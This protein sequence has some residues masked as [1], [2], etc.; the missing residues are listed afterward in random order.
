MDRLFAPV[1]LLLYSMQTSAALAPIA[2]ISDLPT[3]IQ[4]CFQSG[5]C[6][7][8][9]GDIL[10]PSAISDTATATAFSYVD[11]NNGVAE[12]WLMRYELDNT[13]GPTVDSTDYLSAT[14]N[15]VGGVAWLSAMNNYDIENSNEHSFTLYYSDSIFE[16]NPIT[17]TM[18]S[19]DLETGASY[20]DLDA[21]DWSVD[22]GSLVVSPPLVGVIETH[23]EYYFNLLNMTY[24]NGIF[25]FNPNDNRELLYSQSMFEWTPDGNS[26][27]EYTYTSDSLYVS[28]VPLPAAVWLFGSG[29][30]GLIGIARRK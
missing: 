6:F 26:G 3:D 27:K 17:L 11:L 7:Q 22:A 15:K 23:Y 8:A 2:Y 13:L 18:P 20:R 25:S 16:N 5:Y 9:G 24:I 28:S 10:L 4:N 12:K 30:L 1:F 19:V 29:L 14:N 21:L